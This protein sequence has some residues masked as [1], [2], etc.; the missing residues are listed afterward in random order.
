[1]DALLDEGAPRIA[2][3]AP[4]GDTMGNRDIDPHGPFEPAPHPP[5][6]P[7]TAF[8]EIDAKASAL[9]TRCGAPTSGYERVGIGFRRR[10]EGCTIYYHPTLG[11]HEVHGDIRA[12][13]DAMNGPI[14]GLGFPLTDE[15]GVGDPAH[16]QFN[17]FEY[18][19][20]YWASHTGPMVL[21]QQIRD[22]WRAHG[23]V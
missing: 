9:G 8:S 7:V 13:Y 4:M 1:M 11:V 15:R 22:Y 6:V 5:Q 23:G 16:G 2:L 19:S 12:K 21:W 18:G 17:D 20:I 3:R 14:G 10:Y